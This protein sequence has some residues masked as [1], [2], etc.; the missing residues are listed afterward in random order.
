[1]KTSKR[2]LIGL[3]VCV[4]GLVPIASCSID[5]SINN[6]PNSIEQ[7]KLASKAGV[8]GL[9]VGLQSISG[10]FYS[11]DHS[12]LSSLWSWQMSGPPGLGRAQPNSWMNYVLNP[13][14]PQDDE[15]KNGY[16]AVRQSTDLMTYAP[17]VTFS[18]TPEKNVATQ[19]TIVG[20]AETYRALVLG[21]LAADFG[22]IPIT[23]DAVNP[24]PFVSQSAAYA[25]VQRLLD[26]ALAKFTSAGDNSIG[27]GQDLNYGGNAAA[28]IPVVHTLKARYFLHV[29]NYGSALSEAKMGLTDPAAD[30]K[31]LYSQTV[32]EYSPWGH[33]TI[34]EG[35]LTAE[36]AFVDS[37]RSEPGD[38]RLTKYF[39]PN[40]NGHIVG[41]AGHNEV[42]APTSLDS[43]SLD[44]S[45]ASLLS[46]AYG[47]YDSKF[48]LASAAE[49]TLIQA[50][51]EAQTGDIAAAV[52]DV[53]VI[54]AA[55]GLPAFASSD[56]A[57]T[58]AQILK[59]KWLE[60]FLQGQA[61]ND[62]RRTGTL[63]EVVTHTSTR[64]GN[65]RFTYPESET[66]ANPNVP[67]DDDAL[68]NTL[69]G[70]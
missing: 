70:K 19:N 56:Q 31:A 11:G 23:V 33:W 67:P 48:T 53:N 69:L 63:P 3:A 17:R 22:S 66:V 62:M 39:A 34:V 55:A 65:L 44:A 10:D 4:L 30:L 68:V 43:E 41:Y 16:R 26:D 18:N 14:G 5:D 12:R 32:G 54:R 40:K 27:F 35:A 42:I 51:A 37:L 28:W 20:I 52:T 24:P 13:T 8:Y 47:D 57:A 6:S 49:N 7:G 1:M 46:P 50:E 2:N 61:Y 45:L 38:T 60:L 21:E 29:H 9:L 15:W 59:Q 58:I 64:T 36:K 25:E